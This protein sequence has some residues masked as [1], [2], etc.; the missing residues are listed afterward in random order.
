MIRP[1]DSRVPRPK[2]PARWLGLLVLALVCIGFAPRAEARCKYPNRK[3]KWYTVQ[4]G[5]SCWS[6]AI[7]LF[8]DGRKYRIIHRYND[9]GKLPHILKPGMKLCFPSKTPDP[10]AKVEWRKRRVE[11]RPP[12]TADWRRARRNMALW[13]LYNVRTKKQSLAGIRFA[14]R[15]HLAMREL[16]RIVIY[17][18]S[19]QRIRFRALTRRT[20]EVKEGTIRGGL[21]SLDALAGGDK[22][23]KKKKAIVVK[24]PAGQVT[25]RSSSSQIEYNKGKK[26]SVVSVYEGDA[27]VKARGKSVRVPTNF[28]TYVKKGFAP[29]KPKPL[30]PAP[31]WFKKKNRGVAVIVDGSEKRTTFRV[32]WNR[33][34][35]AAYYRVEWSRQKNF[36][37]LVGGRTLPATKDS[38]QS[39]VVPRLI[40][41]PA[42]DTSP[43]MYYVRVSVRDDIG[44]EG[45][46]SKTF[47]IGVVRIKMR[48]RKVNKLYTSV[49]LLQLTPASFSGQ[50]PLEVAVDKEGKSFR[51]LDKGVLLSKPGT[52]TIWLRQSGRSTKTSLKVRILKIRAKFQQPSGR[53]DTSKPPMN[54]TLTISDENNKPASVPGLKFLAY[55]GGLPLEVKATRTANKEP[56]RGSFTASLPRYKQHPGDK[57]WVVAGWPGGELARVEIP[58]APRLVRASLSGPS[59]I[60]HKKGPWE[61]ALQVTENDKPRAKKP[62]KLRMLV[63]P[64]AKSLP[65]QEK[66]NGR[67]VA[68][69]P[70]Y[71]KHPG[72]RVWVVAAWSG[73]ELARKEVKVKKP[74]SPKF[75]WPAMPPSLE[76]AIV[77][78]GTPTRA[79]RP[80]SMVGFT[81]FVQQQPSAQAGVDP[82]VTL[83]FA[84]RGQLAFWKRRI[85]VDVDIPWM[86]VGLLGDSSNINRL[87]DFRLGARV[88]AFEHEKLLIT[89][90]FRVRFP[91]GGIERSRRDFGFEPGVILGWMP[92][93]M[94]QVNTNQILVLNPDLAGGF[95]W[96]YSSSYGVAIRPL[97][98]L[99]LG[100]ELQ[101]ALGMINTNPDLTVGLGIG[102][103]VRFL[104]DRFRIGIIGGGALNDGGQALLGGFSVGLTFDVGFNGI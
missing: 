36:A 101:L 2:Y 85:G 35:Q 104:I 49:G 86:Q 51:P 69:L 33:V 64:G 34:T 54:V 84:V 11:A 43:K 99:S 12:R 91:T 63:Y 41:N 37:E 32:T 14:D 46:F 103:A 47:S 61:F 50:V 81:S 78:P 3:V 16:S 73:G 48:V 102:G 93:S 24:T 68:S 56:I 62:K 29:A 23:K 31:R 20:I 79:A 22:P 66:G 44:L 65:I 89:P 88:V 7:K 71:K 72:K 90:T 8:A 83:R 57:V 13:R 74:P 76:W 4:A 15:S 21:A 45:R 6:I 26:T 95:S 75:K 58:V 60:E 40:P 70:A 19:S 53:L 59:L 82:D 28:G 42:T 97:P 5:E 52:Y 1:I 17:G 25:L 96:F 94:V 92:H 18:R 98:Y 87:G 67:F 30:P 38:T 9:L 100:V 80:V 10:D 39:F 27:D 55:P 77:G